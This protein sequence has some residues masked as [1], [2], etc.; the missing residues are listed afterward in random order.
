VES[1]SSLSG[2]GPP[3]FSKAGTTTTEA[4]ALLAIFERCALHQPIAGGFSL[5]LPQF[6]SKNESYTLPGFFPTPATRH[7]SIP[8]IGEN[9]D[10]RQS[11]S[12]QLVLPRNPERS[13]HPI[14]S[15]GTRLGH[16]FP[17][18]AVATP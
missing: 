7:N 12:Q 18:G 6:L 15:C 4:A 1:S 16:P 5:V 14:H 11:S 13:T 9:S 8:P 2:A 17:Q 10:P 3:L